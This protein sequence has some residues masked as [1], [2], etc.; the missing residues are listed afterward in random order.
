MAKLTYKQGGHTLPC[1]LT[2]TTFRSRTKTCYFLTS[3]TLEQS[4]III[5]N[6]RQYNITFGNALL[7]LTQVAMTRVLY[8]RFIRGDIS[9]S[10]WEY[11][12]K[13][14]MNIGGPLNIRPY[15]EEDWL[16]RGGGGEVFLAIS[17]YFYHLPFMTLGTTRNQDP[18]TLRLVNGAP[19]FA[20][21]LTFNRFLHRA[22]LVKTQAKQFFQH[23]FFTEIAMGHHADRNGSTMMAATEWMRSVQEGSEADPGTAVDSFLGSTM[24]LAHGGASMGDVSITPSIV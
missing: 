16:A 20:D 2:T 18:A 4:A 15:L 7:V 11:R 19:P 22:N 10:E 24:V 13:Q 3:L 1:K 14:P 9:V 6:C 21:L 8:K 12:K 17:F 5:A 23:P